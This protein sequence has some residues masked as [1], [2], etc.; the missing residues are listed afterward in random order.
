MIDLHRLLRLEPANDPALAEQ[1]VVRDI[2][3]RDQTFDWWFDNDPPERNARESEDA[4]DIEYES[5]T[6]DFTHEGNG[7]PCRFY[8]RAREGC[9]NGA[10]CRFRHAPDIRSVRDEL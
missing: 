10:R 4:L 6:E 3:G 9:K 7:T 2:H 5:D 8:N 1:R